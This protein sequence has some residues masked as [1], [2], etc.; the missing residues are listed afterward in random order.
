MK[1]GTL[2]YRSSVFLL[3]SSHTWSSNIFRFSLPV[4]SIIETSSLVSVV[5]SMISSCPGFP[6]NSTRRSV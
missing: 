5:P 4:T 6:E 3:S 1:E 2:Y